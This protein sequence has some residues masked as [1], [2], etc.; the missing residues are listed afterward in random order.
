MSWIDITRVIDATTPIY[1]GDPPPRIRTRTDRAGIT[2]TRLEFL[3]HTGTHLDL[4]GHLFAGAAPPGDATILRALLGRAWVARPR[5][6]RRAEITVEDLRAVLPRRCPRRLLLRAGRDR[7]LALDAA[8]WIAKRSLLVGTDGLSIDPAGGGLDAHRILLDSGVLILEN[9]RLDDAA[10][11]SY[12]L[13]SLP[14]RLS[15]DDGAPV[16]ALLRREGRAATGG[17]G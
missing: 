14:L 15:V 13:V 12:H 9:L 4:P 3:T 5:G 17:R 1:P 11:G 8:R 10:P 16:R 7:G 2:M 6:V